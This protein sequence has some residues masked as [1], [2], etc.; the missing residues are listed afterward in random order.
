[1]KSLV[2]IIMLPA[3]MLIG[4]G[5]MQTNEATAGSA[6]EQ[7]NSNGALS[8]ADVNSIDSSMHDQTIQMSQAGTSSILMKVGGA[9]LLVNFLDQVTNDPQE[10]A[11]IIN[12]IEV[13]QQ[14]ISDPKSFQGLVASLV[15]SQLQGVDIFGVPLTDLVQAGLGLING[16]TSQANFSNLFGTIIRGAFNMFL[17]N[18]PIGNIISAIAGPVL[19]GVNGNNQA[20]GNAGSNT[21]NANNNQNNNNNNNS[22]GGLLGTVVN[23]IGSAVG[24]SAGGGLVGG[25]FSLI[26]NLFK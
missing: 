26:T 1:M 16:D 19:G 8:D 14:V 12:G 13:T 18:S 3:L 7:L 22:G 23:A 10:T 5:K 21:N 4:C 6:L 15:A 25:L 24:G 2:L 11:M 17:S 9:D 20:S